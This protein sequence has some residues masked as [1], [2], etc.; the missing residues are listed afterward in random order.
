[1]GGTPP[2]GMMKVGRFFDPLR[3]IKHAKFHFYKMNILRAMK[4]VQERGFAFVM[5]MAFTTLPCTS[6]LASDLRLK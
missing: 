2:G 4:W 1:V 5:H 3:I 6:A